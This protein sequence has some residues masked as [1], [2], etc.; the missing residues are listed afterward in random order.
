MEVLKGDPQYHPKFTVLVEEIRDSA[1]ARE[2]TLLVLLYSAIFLIGFLPSAVYR[3][4]F[5]ATSIVYAP[6]IWAVHSTI[7]TLLP[8]KVRLERITKGELE[9]V[10]RGFSWI[11]IGVLGAKAGLA[12]GFVDPKILAEKFP[13]AR[14]AELLLVPG[15]WPWWQLTLLTDAVLTFILLFFADA[16][17]ARHEGS[18]PWPERTVLDVTSTIS[19]VRVTLSLLTIAHFFGLALHIAFPTVAWPW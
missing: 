9:K 12:L 6:F 3:I 14:A 11:V 17:L 5:K 4:S 8:L 15:G 16:A 18:H 10:R 13:T 1:G 19:F 7:W 2:K